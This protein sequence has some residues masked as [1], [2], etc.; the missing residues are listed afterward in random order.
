M[1][2]AQVKGPGILSGHQNSFGLIVIYVCLFFKWGW[3]IR[4]F[5]RN[6]FPKIKLHLTTGIR[7]SY[8]PRWFRFKAHLNF[9]NQKTATV[10]LCSLHIHFKSDTDN[11]NFSTFTKVKSKFLIHSKL[12]DD[13][14]I[15]DNYVVKLKLSIP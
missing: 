6:K 11:T 12:R 4:T 8:I 1:E 7:N 13:L 2:M 5:F 15:Y 10:K 9:K 3:R 14:S